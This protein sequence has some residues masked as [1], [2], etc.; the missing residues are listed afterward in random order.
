MSEDLDAL[1]ELVRLKALTRA[2]WVRVGVRRPESVAAHSWGV[3]LLVLL[4]L[5][6][7]MDRGRALAYAVLHDLAEVRVGDLTPADGV[8]AQ[9][10]SDLEQHAMAGLCAPVRHGDQLVATWRPFGEGADPEARFVRQL[11]KVDMAVQAVAYA[12][13]ADT[14]EFLRSAEASVTDP[15]LVE[16]LA[17]LR[18][19]L[20]GASRRV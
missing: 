1:L 5:P 4:L 17:G 9:A 8:P 6:E 14:H 7:D 10:K 12:D 16:L 13:E 15:D 2:G 3:A 20:D 11:D 19:H 18:R